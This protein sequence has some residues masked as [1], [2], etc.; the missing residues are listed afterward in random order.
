MDFNKSMSG[1]SAVAGAT[2][3]ELASL[4]EAAQA[5]GELAIFGLAGSGTTTVAATLAAGVN[6]STAD[7]AQLGN[8]SGGATGA[9]A[10]PGAF[11]MD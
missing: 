8:R 10:C 5:Q 11:R 6:K 7:V 3:A 9:R 1:V 2:A 4:R